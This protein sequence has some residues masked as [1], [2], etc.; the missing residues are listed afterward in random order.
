MTNW[1]LRLAG[2]LLLLTTAWYLPWALGHLNW[3]APWLAMYGRKV[4]FQVETE[5]KY[6]GYIQREAR[7]ARNLAEKENKEIPDWIDYEEIASLSREAREKLGEVRPRSVGQASRV[8]GITPADV[9]S[10]LIHLE[11]GRRSAASK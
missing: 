7:R 2:L 5:V 4:R 8:P 11:K 6:D 1:K 9:A 10:L 3:D